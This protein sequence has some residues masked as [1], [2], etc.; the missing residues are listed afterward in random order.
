MKKNEEAQ[1]NFYHRNRIVVCLPKFSKRNSTFLHCLDTFNEII[2][3]YVTWNLVFFYWQMIID[4][5]ITVILVM[6][7]AIEQP[8]F[9]HFSFNLFSAGQLG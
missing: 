3:F 5:H 9:I 1:V 4:K 6:L 2:C 7:F 8:F